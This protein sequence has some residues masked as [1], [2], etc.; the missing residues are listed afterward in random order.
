MSHKQCTDALFMNKKSTTATKKKKKRKL[1]RENKMQN[2][3]SKQILNKGG[4][5][6]VNKVPVALRPWD[7]HGVIRLT[8]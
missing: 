4:R 2:A 5:K 6:N 7:V 8:W 3:G 1:K